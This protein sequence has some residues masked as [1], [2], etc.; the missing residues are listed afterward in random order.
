M[1]LFAFVLF[2]L[3]AFILFYSSVCLFV[4]FVCYIY[5]IRVFV[6]SVFI[7]CV[8]FIHLLQNQNQNRN[9]N[10][11]MNQ[12]FMNSN[13][14]SNLNSPHFL[15]GLKLVFLAFHTF[16]F[17]INAFFFFIFCSSGILLNQQSSF[18]NVSFESHSGLY[19]PMQFFYFSFSFFIIFNA[20]IFRPAIINDFQHSSFLNGQP[21]HL[22]SQRMY[23]KFV[24]SLSFFVSSF[25]CVCMCVC[26][27][28]CVCVWQKKRE[29][30]CV[31]VCSRERERV[32]GKV[33]ACVCLAEKERQR[34]KE[35]E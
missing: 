7:N 16:F 22:Q 21:G 8:R 28:V 31:C 5:C 18:Q 24:L 14:F 6:F 1:N 2:N 34:E 29:R 35:K 33:C 4:T 13:A 20:F 30:Q 23:D 9:R 15:N 17:L 25:V 11:D 12:Y 27:C 3:F 10:L 19:S 26:L 32:G